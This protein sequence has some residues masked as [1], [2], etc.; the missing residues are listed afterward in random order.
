MQTSLQCASHQLMS[1]RTHMHRCRSASFACIH[2][3][4]GP[5]STTGVSPDG[6]VPGGGGGSLSGGG[7]SPVPLSAA[8]PAADC[9]PDAAPAPA[10]LARADA[11]PA[12]VAAAVS[13]AALLSAA[14][15]LR[16]DARLFFFLASS[17]STVD[18]IPMR[19][20]RALP[21]LVWG[22]DVKLQ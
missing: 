12:S 21:G 13:A 10:P 19:T 9:A 3:D 11:T 6:V 14:A 5:A 18:F 1:R 2:T 4:L 7:G 15:V 8:P 20:R 16:F 17:A 22:T